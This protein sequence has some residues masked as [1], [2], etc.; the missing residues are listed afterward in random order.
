MAS[1]RGRER[2]V[3][4]VL[5]LPLL[6]SEKHMLSLGHRPMAVSRCPP[7]LLPAATWNV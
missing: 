4:R 6:W 1:L 7:P 3:C 5:F 2:T